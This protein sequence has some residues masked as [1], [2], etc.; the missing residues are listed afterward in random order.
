MNDESVTEN[1]V[2]GNYLEY[3]RFNSILENYHLQ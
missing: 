3:K 2:Y 1:L